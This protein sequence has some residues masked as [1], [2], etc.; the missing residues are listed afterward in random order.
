MNAM[1]ETESL[2]RCEASARLLAASRAATW[3]PAPER[4]PNR[5][6]RFGDFEVRYAPFAGDFIDGGPRPASDP[7]P[8]G[9]WDHD[10]HDWLG[11]WF[12]TRAEAV[13]DARE[14]AALALQDELCERIG[15]ISKLERLEAIAA[16]IKAALA[17]KDAR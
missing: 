11:A 5:R 6:I 10:E 15:S 1:L 16:A 14:R 2:E 3:S 9:L 4:R 8:W 13:R 17:R 7:T 12:A